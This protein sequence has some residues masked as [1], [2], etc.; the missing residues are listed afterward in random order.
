MFL[1]KLSI[2]PQYQ[3]KIIRGSVLHVKGPVIIY[4]GGVLVIMKKRG[5]DA[6]L[7]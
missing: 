7:E 5:G 3:T 4:A 1:S 2:K 6:F